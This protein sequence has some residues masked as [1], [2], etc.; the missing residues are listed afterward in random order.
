[1][2][3]AH[4][5]AELDCQCRPALV[6][7]GK[8]LGGFGTNRAATQTD[9]PSF[10]PWG[11]LRAQQDLHNQVLELSQKGFAKVGNRFAPASV[12]RA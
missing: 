1:L 5:L 6:T 4:F 7:D 3:R 12:Y 10:Q 9:V 2:I 8:V 11:G